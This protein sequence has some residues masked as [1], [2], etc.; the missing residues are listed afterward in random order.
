MR[1]DILTILN[2]APKIKF[3]SS[4]LAKHFNYGKNKKNE[5]LLTIVEFIVVQEKNQATNP[6][7]YIEERR[8][9]FMLTAFENHFVFLFKICRIEL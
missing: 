7:Y 3:R 2:N 5:L 6:L 8:Y 1:Y 9:C 4:I